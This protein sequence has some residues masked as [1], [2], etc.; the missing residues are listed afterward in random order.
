MLG[1]RGEDACYVTVTGQHH[2][3]FLSVSTITV[4]ITVIVTVTVT[5]TYGLRCCLKTHPLSHKSRSSL[6]S[7]RLGSSK[8]KDHAA[9][10][11][12]EPAEKPGAQPPQLRQGVSRE[13]DE[14]KDAGDTGDRK[15][16][17]E[18]DRNLRI[19]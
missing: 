13:A 4:T 12:A 18:H 5:V 3:F 9:A 2:V 15:I 10:V 6:V 11:R 1:E 14:G 8:G 16:K 7:S 17:Q 19:R